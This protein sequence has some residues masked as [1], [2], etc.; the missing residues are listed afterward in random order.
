MATGIQQRLAFSAILAIG[1][2]LP[3][4][5]VG[6]W[7][8][9]LF[10]YHPGILA[11]VGWAITLPAVVVASALREFHYAISWILGLVVEG[12]VIFALLSGWVFVTRKRKFEPRS[13]SRRTHGL[14][15]L[16]LAN[17]ALAYVLVGYL[18]EI[19]PPLSTPEKLGTSEFGSIRR[20]LLIGT[21]IDFGP[22]VFA[23]GKLFV[24]SNAGLIQ[25]EGTKP[26]GVYRWHV[27]SRI[28][29]VW[30]GPKGQSIWIQQAVSSNLATLDDSG[31]RSVDLPVP[32][33]GYTRGDM[34]AGIRIASNDEN[35]WMSGGSALWKWRADQSRWIP[36]PV[37]GLRSSYEGIEVHGTKGAPIILRG[38]NQMFGSGD[39]A[40]LLEGTADD[41]W[42]ETKLPDCCVKDLT[43]IGESIFYRNKNGELVRVSK[44]KAELVPS[45]GRIEAI[46]ADNG[47]LVVSVADVGVFAFGSK[48]TKLFDPPYP[49][50][51]KDA[52]VHIAAHDGVIALS[53]TPSSTSSGAVRG[54]AL[55]VSEGEKLIKVELLD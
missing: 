38:A 20:K 34:L 41:R 44:G 21:P 51:E 40:A 54:N 47:Q 28:D 27:H 11:V 13:A 42:V 43:T 7:L 25:V 35:I 15:A 46:C 52:W 49:L 1:L 30:G 3:L 2:A 18:E 10:P 14:A 53:F 22:L 45:P 26:T 19:R 29:G 12:V 32:E 16:F 17:L 36:V 24:A 6:L 4:V 5:V 55:W 37:P 8:I 9:R 39:G 48:W 31:W 23:R 33:R 50:G